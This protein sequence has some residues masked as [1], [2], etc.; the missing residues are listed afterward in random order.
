VRDAFLSLFLRPALS[1]D[2]KTLDIY[3][4]IK[5]AAVNTQFQ[6]SQDGETF[7]TYVEGISKKTE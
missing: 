5:D 2:K 1:A 6:I 7:I 4:R 3:T